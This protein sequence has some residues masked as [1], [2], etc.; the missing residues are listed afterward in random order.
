MQR[1]ISPI[2]VDPRDAP[3]VRARGRRTSRSIST[4][5]S[6]RSFPKTASS[7]TA[8][9]KRPGRPTCGS[10]SPNP[11]SPT[12]TAC[13]PS[14]PAIPTRAKLWRRITSD[15]EAEMMPPPDSH[16]ELKPRT[17]RNAQALDRT[18]AP[19]T[20]STGRSSR[21]SK[22][23]LPEVSDK[24]WPRNEIDRF[25]LARL[26]AEELAAVAAKPTVARSSAG[27]RSTSPAC[28]PPPRKSKPS[29]PTNRP[30]PTKNSS[31]ACSPARTSASAWPSIWLDAARYADTNG[32][33]ID[34][35]RHMWLWRDWV[36]NAFNTQ[37][38]VRPVPPRTARRRP[39]AEP[40][41]SRSSSPP[42]SSATT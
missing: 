40:H 36:I 8:S 6:A 9:T 39:A 13:P 10:T 35:G 27:S 20:P 1:T 34:G 41:R 18:R 31:T 15:D 11:P 24:A 30:T 37:P 4:A 32:Y 16:R 29:S 42:A 2:P 7:A 17:K 22:P 38:A 28:R 25:V 5:T 14:S 21:R 26:D 3:S 19:P 23:T 33:S 12:A